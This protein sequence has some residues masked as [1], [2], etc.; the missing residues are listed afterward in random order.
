MKI[1]NVGHFGRER[2]YWWLGSVWQ[3]KTLANESRRWVA[4]DFDDFRED[5]ADLEED[6]SVFEDDS[7]DFW[8]QKRSFIGEKR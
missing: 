6:R 2:Q 7:A 3:R 4:D 5:R 8:G 1:E